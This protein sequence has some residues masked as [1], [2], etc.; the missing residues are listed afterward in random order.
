MKTLLEKLLNK[1]EIKEN[2]CWIWTGSKTPTG[3][4]HLTHFKKDFYTHRVS[5]EIFNQKEIPKGMCVCHFCDN[6]S[7]INPEHLW[8]GTMTEN[9]AD[10]DRKGRGRGGLVTEE[11]KRAKK[12]RNK[13]ITRIKV[14]IQ[15][16]KNSLIFNLNKD[17]KKIWGYN[18]EHSWGYEL[19][20]DYM[21]NYYYKWL[22]K[23]VKSYPPKRIG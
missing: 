6:P 11:M 13:Q 9:I 3:Y 7:C 21:L 15:E 20:N 2:E 1:T 19:S 22:N 10:R 8:L 16:R 23:L 17:F 14:F 5:F 12:K 4:G 18:P